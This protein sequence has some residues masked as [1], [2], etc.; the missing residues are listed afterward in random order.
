MNTS[1]L[2]N[3]VITGRAGHGKTLLLTKLMNDFQKS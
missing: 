1:D 2:K 3:I